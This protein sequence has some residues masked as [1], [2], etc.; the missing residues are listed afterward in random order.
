[1]PDTFIKI[2]SATVGAGG[3]ASMDFTSIPSTYTDLCVLLSARSTSSTFQGSGLKVNGSTGNVYTYRR[4]EGTGSSAVS[5]SG[6]LDFLPIGTIP[7]TSQTSNT[8]T[9]QL[10]YIPNYA[11]S[12]TYKSI[13]VDSVSENNATASYQQLIAG[14]YSANTAITS[15]K[16]E[17]SNFAQYSTATLYGI[18][19][20]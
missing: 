4:L 6:T 13:S 18:K 17:A 12:T 14:I 2:A 11:S 19:N 3:A 10:I 20:S 1:M 5:D 8:F 15:I 7:G 9:N 16:L